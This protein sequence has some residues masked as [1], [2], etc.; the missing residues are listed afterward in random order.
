MKKSTQSVLPK[1]ELALHKDLIRTFR[2]FELQTVVEETPET[3]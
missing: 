3:K 1:I 2:S